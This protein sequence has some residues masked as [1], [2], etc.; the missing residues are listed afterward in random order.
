MPKKI[1][2]EAPP[3]YPLCLH[4]DCPRA[5]HCLH[6]VAYG[7]LIGKCEMLSVINPERCQKDGDECP[8]LLPRRCPGGL[9]PRLHRDAAADVSRPVQAVHALADGALRPQPIF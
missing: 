9:R 7:E 6:R 8:P 4:A 1:Y 3:H 2:K 5:G